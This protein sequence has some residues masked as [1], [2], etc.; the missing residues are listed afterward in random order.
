MV[1]GSRDAETF[2]ASRGA[3]SDHRDQN[4]TARDVNWSLAG[5]VVKKGKEAAMAWGAQ[6]LPPL[7]DA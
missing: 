7:T 1:T 5:R 3:T 4:Q 2:K 6:G